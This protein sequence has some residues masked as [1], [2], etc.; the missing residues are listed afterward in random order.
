MTSRALRG[1]LEGGQGVSD[2]GWG[3]GEQASHLDY[4]TVSCWQLTHRRIFELWDK[5]EWVA[6]PWCAVILLTII[7]LVI[8]RDVPRDTFLLQRVSLDR[9]GCSEWQMSHPS[10]WIGQFI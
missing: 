4:N 10:S 3:E 5:E 8:Q 2:T 1:F 9:L 6:C 7:C